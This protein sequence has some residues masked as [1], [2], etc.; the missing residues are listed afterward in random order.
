MSSEGSKEVK[1]KEDKS[2]EKSVEASAVAASAPTESGAKTDDGQPVA[3]DD[4]VAEG[5]GA[6]DVAP[7]EKD[8]DDQVWLFCCY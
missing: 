1:T 2:D 6:G 5:E 7:P 3:V 8:N 4:K